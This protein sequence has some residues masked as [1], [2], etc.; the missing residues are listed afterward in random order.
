LGIRKIPRSD[1]STF[2]FLDEFHGHVAQLG[3]NPAPHQPGIVGL[4]QPAS[5]A[6][7]L[8]DTPTA[9]DDY[10]KLCR[11]RVRLR[12]LYLAFGLKLI[13]QIVTVSSSTLLVKFVGAL[14][15]LL[16]NRDQDGRFARLRGAEPFQQQIDNGGA[17]V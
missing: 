12:A 2:A 1:Y 14:L 8:A 16:L 10:R 7:I 11:C 15:N 6:T 17:Q 5:P 3:I 4:Q 9:L 13:V